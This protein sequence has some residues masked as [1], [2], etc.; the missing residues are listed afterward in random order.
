MQPITLIRINKVKVLFHSI[1]RP[2]CRKLDARNGSSIPQ[3]WN[4]KGL[5]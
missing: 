5:D 4:E 2:V 1:G 3:K